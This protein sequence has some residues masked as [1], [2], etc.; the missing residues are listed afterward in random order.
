[1]QQTSAGTNQKQAQEN[2]H[3]QKPSRNKAQTDPFKPENQVGIFQKS[4]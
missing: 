2:Q 1:M 3:R 4:Q